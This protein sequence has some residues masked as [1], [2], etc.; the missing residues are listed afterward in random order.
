LRYA[1]FTLQIQGIVDYSA[2]F[3]FTEDPSIARFLSKIKPWDNQGMLNVI[4][5]LRSRSFWHVSR[6]SDSLSTIANSIHPRMIE[7][8]VTGASKLTIQA[9]EEVKISWSSSGFVYFVHT[10]VV[11]RL[12]KRGDI[13]NTYLPGQLFAFENSLGVV[14]FLIHLIDH[15]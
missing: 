4:I 8:M 13:V 14:P 10:G 11:N 15:L 3:S 6:P 2:P 7:T 9:N 12:N 5:D 1:Y